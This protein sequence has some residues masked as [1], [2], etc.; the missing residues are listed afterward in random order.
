MLR[1]GLELITIAG[2][3][4]RAERAQGDPERLGHPSGSWF[5]RSVGQ[6]GGE[7]FG[8]ALRMFKAIS[9]CVDDTTGVTYLAK[10]DVPPL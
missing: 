3:S 10:Q 2:E 7:P 1:D 5:R 6:L 9:A 4:A 8:S